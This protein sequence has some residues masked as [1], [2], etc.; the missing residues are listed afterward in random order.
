MNLQGFETLCMNYRY[1][2][3]MASNLPCERVNA[4]GGE[5]W[6]AALVF[7]GTASAILTS[8]G[9]VPTNEGLSTRSIQLGDCEAQ[10]VS[11]K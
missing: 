10:L 3:S 8:Q 5:A 11:E 6:L 7:I 2:S 4:C 9:K 1:S